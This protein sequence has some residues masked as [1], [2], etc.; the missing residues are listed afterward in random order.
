MRQRIYP[1]IAYQD[2]VTALGWLTTAF[3]FTEHGE[4]FV[5]DDGTVGHAEL[6]VGG[7]QIVMVATPNREYQ[8]PKSH[9]ETCEAAGRWQDNPW[10]IDGLLVIVDD[11][12]AHHARAVAAG[13]QVI[14]PLEEGP[15]GRLYTAEDLEGHRW[16]FQQARSDQ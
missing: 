13:A 16:M 14:R 1:M 8:G 15:D 10:V 4:R 7:G 2:T 9:R 3:G 11:L 12:D 5:M 6:D